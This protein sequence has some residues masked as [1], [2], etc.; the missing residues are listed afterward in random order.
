MGQEGVQPS[1]LALPE[2]SLRRS[3]TASSTPN[4]GLSDCLL[5]LICLYRNIYSSPNVILK[6]PLQPWP[7]SSAGW[8]IDP[9]TQMAACS[10]PSWDMYRKQPI[11]VSLSHRCLS[12]STINKHTPI[13]CEPTQRNTHGQVAWNIKDKDQEKCELK[14]EVK[15]RERNKDCGVLYYKGQ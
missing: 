15:A 6:Y 12:V 2:H 14:S 10:I 1:S 4:A 3:I 8:S 7:G 5:T 13:G 11:N 9:Y